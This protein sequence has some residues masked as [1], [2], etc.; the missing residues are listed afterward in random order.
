MSDW[1][2]RL[3]LDHSDIIIKK[4]LQL[5]FL[6]RKLNQLGGILLYLICDFFN[7][8]FIFDILD[9]SFDHLGL[10]VQLADLLLDSYLVLLNLHI[11][12]TLFR[13]MMGGHFL[14][15][16]LFALFFNNFFLFLLQLFLSFFLCL[17][18]L[19]ADLL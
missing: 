2:W 8:L 4:L 11:L 1:L 19:L 17:L 12:M 9:L 3:H 6:V 18:V 13:S 14:L 5:S 15:H 16:F 10:V 7:F